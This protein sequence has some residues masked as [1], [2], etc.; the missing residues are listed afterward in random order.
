MGSTAHAAAAVSGH[1]RQPLLGAGDR[2][3]GAHH[4][5]RAVWGRQR[6]VFAEPDHDVVDVRDTQRPAAELFDLLLDF[7]QRRQAEAV[8]SSGSNGSV[9]PF[10]TQDA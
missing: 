9:V 5:V 1:I 6:R 2:G 7:R 10:R 4:R 3:G 8:G